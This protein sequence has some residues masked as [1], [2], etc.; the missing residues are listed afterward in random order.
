MSVGTPLL[1]ELV[2]KHN[3]YKL[4]RKTEKKFSAEPGN[5][6][7]YHS[8][9]FNGIINNNVVDV[10]LK[11][12]PKGKKTQSGLAFWTKSGR[13]NN[14]YPAKQWAVSK[15][16]FKKADQIRYAEYVLFIYIFIFSFSFSIYSYTHNISSSHILSFY[17]LFH[18]SI[19]K[20][21][22]DAILLHITPFTP[23]PALSTYSPYHVRHVLYSTL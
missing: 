3:A 15:P 22:G 12:A 20:Q 18:S 7:G 4:G 16:S 2:R 1:W 5:L 6:L 17:L 10:R 19:I 14:R 23:F 8:Q 21:Y 13:R 11:K 9:K